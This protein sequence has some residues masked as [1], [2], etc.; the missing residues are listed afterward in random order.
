MT[1]ISNRRILHVLVL[2]LATAGA[3]AQKEELPDVTEDGLH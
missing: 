3:S 2:T 1:T